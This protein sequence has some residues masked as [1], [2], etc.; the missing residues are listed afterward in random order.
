MDTNLSPAAYTS[1][2]LPTHLAYRENA[3]P[4]ISWAAF[5]PTSP[6]RS[7]LRSSS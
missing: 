2:A 3:G 1:E 5:S 4:S 7:P 6:P